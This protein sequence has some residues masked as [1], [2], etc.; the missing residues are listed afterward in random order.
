MGK[1]KD[2]R[3]NAW[4]WLAGECQFV[5]CCKAMVGIT[6]AL[7]LAPW[8][9]FQSSVRGILSSFHI[10]CC[11]GIQSSVWPELRITSAVFLK[12]QA[13]N[14]ASSEASYCRVLSDLEDEK[15][16]GNL[17]QLSILL[18]SN[19]KG[20]EKI[21]PNI[22][23]FPRSLGEGG[24]EKGRMSLTYTTQRIH[25]MNYRCTCQHHSFWGRW[26]F[27]FECEPGSSLVLCKVF[28]LLNT[29]NSPLRRIP[30]GTWCWVKLGPLCR[31]HAGG[32]CFPSVM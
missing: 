19:V 6:S 24:W 15:K 32:T 20:K 17:L 22:L 12:D 13:R 2:R 26:L 11:A 30:W 3:E 29:P 25:G 8:N 21:P 27:S 28:V 9:Y 18:K 1:Q 7:S 16:A 4:N 23:Y 10:K 5:N 31:V 14:T